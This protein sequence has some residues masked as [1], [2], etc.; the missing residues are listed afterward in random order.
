MNGPMPV[1]AG[2]D[3]NCAQDARRFKRGFALKL[4]ILVVQAIAW[5]RLNASSS[6]TR[7]SLLRLV[8]HADTGKPHSQPGRLDF[9]I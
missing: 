4:T 2:I 1:V 3:T 9:Q 8:E 6:D 7:R 5:R